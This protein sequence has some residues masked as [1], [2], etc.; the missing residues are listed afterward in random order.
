MALLSLT[1]TSS[2]STFSLDE[3]DVVKVYDR[4]SQT[5]IEAVQGEVSG[6]KFF[7][8][9]ETPSAISTSAS[10]LFST[11]FQGNKI[12][13]NSDRI[14]SVDEV[15]SLARVTYDGN[16]DKPEVLKL[17]VD[18]STFEAAIPSSG[19][20]YSSYVAKIRSNGTNPPI[21]SVIKNELSGSISWTRNSIGD[22]N[23]ELTGA[24]SGNV[25]FFHNGIVGVESYVVDNDNVG[26]LS[27]DLLGVAADNL[28]NSFNIEV[29]VYS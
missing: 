13:L 28:S 22:Y 10:R 16:G 6:T 26:V 9:D 2:G 21:V 8:V 18:K 5:V 4:N 12:Y 17:D 27:Y 23:G 19:T 24:F 29:R 14:I 1:Q 15:S 3:S 25:A 20:G 7:Q 11:T